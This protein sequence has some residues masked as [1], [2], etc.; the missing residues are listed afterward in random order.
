MSIIELGAELNKM[1]T[2]APNKE[3]V[4][5]IHLFGIKYGDLILK[6]KYSVAEIVKSSGINDSYKTEVQKGIKLSKYVA[7]KM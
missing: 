1:Y 2:N 7:S 3:Q 4:T 5:F 6:N